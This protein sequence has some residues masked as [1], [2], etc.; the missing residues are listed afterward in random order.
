MNDE[1]V[2]VNSMEENSMVTNPYVGPRTFTYEQR[3]LFF[4]REREARDL[5]ARV[6][7]ERLL[8]FYAQ[9]GAGKSS[10]LHTRLIPQLR[11]EEHFAVLPIGRVGGELT[12]GVADV[13]NIYLY[14]LM[15]S[16]D[17]SNVNPQR[18]AQLSLSQFLAQLTSDDGYHWY[19]NE[20]VQSAAP[21]EGVP[22]ANGTQAEQRYILIIDQFEE[23][24]T[25]HPHRRQAREE[26]FRQLDRAIMA[27]PNLWVVLTMREDYVAALDPYAHL[28]TDKLRARFYMERMKV[29]A[30][31][32]AIKQPA[33]LS[34]HPF[35]DE[36]ADALVDNLRRVKVFGQE[37][38]QLEDSVEPVQLQVVCYQLWERLYG[39][40]TPAADE[41]ET[42]DPPAT[43]TVAAPDTITVDTLLQLA[44][45]QE[46][47]TLVDQALGNYYE[48]TL[49]TVLDAS[50]GLV[51]ERQ[52]RDW[53]SNAL[54]DAAG[55]RNLVSFSGDDGTVVGLPHATV[56]MLADHYLLRAESRAGGIWY[57][58]V[59]DR[60]IEPV[61]VANRTWLLNQ[62][63]PV[64]SA[65]RLWE[66]NDRA[67]DLLLDGELLRQA[68]QFAERNPLLLGTLELEFL[69][70][71]KQ[72]EEVAR[73]KRNQ[74]LA[75]IMTLAALMAL[76]GIIYAFGQRS[77]ANAVLVANYSN[78]EADR[79]ID[80]ALLLA[81]EAVRIHNSPETQSQLHYALARSNEPELALLTGHDSEV[82][83]AAYSPD[84]TFIATASKDGSVILWDA[85]SYQKIRRLQAPDANLSYYRVAISP[86]SKLV[87]AGGFAGY[88]V[89]WDAE[90]GEFIDTRYEHR[91]SIVSLVFTPDGSQLLTAGLDNQIKRWNVATWEA[92]L[93]GTHD[94][95]I[96][97]VALSPDGAILASAGRDSKVHLWDLT[98]PL[99]MAPTMTLTDH[100]TV[101]TSV[102]FHPTLTKTVLASGDVSSQLILWD[103]DP[104]R[105]DGKPP[106]HSDPAK[107]FEAGYVWGLAFSPDGTKLATT[108]SRNLLR[109]WQ[110]DIGQE[111]PQMV[112]APLSFYLKGH[113][114]DVADVA[115][116]PDGQQV[117]L[118]SVD[119]NASVWAVDSGSLLTAEADNVSSM[120]LIDDD[121]TLLTVNNTGML[122]A[123]DLTMRQ[124]LWQ[125]PIDTGE[126]IARTLLS[127][128]G[129]TLLAAMANGLMQLRDVETGE[130][131]WQ[132]QSKSPA[133]VTALALSPDKSQVAATQSDGT[134]S[135]WHIHDEEQFGGSTIGHQEQ[136]GAL[137]FS[138]DGRLL[139]S[140][141]CRS[142]TVSAA[143][144][145]PGEII[146]WDTA[147]RLQQGEPLSK[148]GS[149]ISR[150][151]S[152]LGTITALAFSHN[153]HR[154]ASG[155]K[156]GHVVIW[157]VG[158]RRVF[159]EHEEFTKAPREPVAA[160]LFSPDD[161]LLVSAGPIGTLDD[162]AGTIILWDV[163]RGVRFGRSLSDHEQGISALALS[164]DGKRLYSTA[165]DNYIVVNNL[166]INYLY[167]RACQIANRNLTAREWER[168]LR[169]RLYRQTCPRQ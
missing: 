72:R 14:N 23:I 66:E 107:I 13:A 42:P 157:D 151:Y 104:W 94:N 80:T 75:V 121:A 22:A 45:N 156:L 24:L 78:L 41:R 11:M 70:V 28:L 1:P 97:E 71:A 90:S 53:F 120:V 38:I 122:R 69:E 123:W 127:D 37:E 73:A 118:A 108:S 6:V 102:A 64:T 168:Y 40:R 110:F 166:D 81:V 100:N 58:L 163:E 132:E 21:N 16:L 99:P 96:W 142:N 52:L 161:K 98:Q 117:V 155:T 47:A 103:L 17:Q 9:S 79:N 101:V 27:D 125:K 112:V 10:L 165:P 76:V 5:M 48:R 61:L 88:L 119:G 68:E 158:E 67:A 18:L 159:D 143:I 105:K 133:T 126:Q 109:Y 144:G 50:A 43:P 139:A 39:K 35:A 106:L 113:L 15:T 7:S 83:G 8:L 85:E 25:A 49:R 54:I 82:W 87:V 129:T 124:L 140:G 2:V 92:T 160:L 44:G 57:E 137:A 46:L 148:Q 128:D 145:C 154:L 74:Y 65:A 84:G 167:E 33:Q 51:G 26:F 91:D 3:H 34:G 169:G 29:D 63:N 55:T 146:L 59:H 147:L 152:T 12:G 30:A 130:L 86:D 116:R 56:T 141:G 62:S 20:S 95:W 131:L 31:L 111:V 162:D 60:F 19:Y 135:H 36:A 114:D 77:I 149:G 164:K 89:I 93:L 136:V 32:A 138:H 153:D 134:I 4:G 150:G 115:F